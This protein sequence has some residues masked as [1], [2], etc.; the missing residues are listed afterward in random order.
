[1]LFVGVCGRVTHAMAT[2][3]PSMM[4]CRSSAR[5]GSLGSDRVY[6]VR[7]DWWKRARPVT[8][9]MDGSPTA[10]GCTLLPWEPACPTVRYNNA[11]CRSLGLAV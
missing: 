6:G 2:L 1:M 10:G 7:R 8:G 3:L 4:M 5:P 9:D 11:E